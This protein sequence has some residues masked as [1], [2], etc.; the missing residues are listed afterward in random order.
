MQWLRHIAAWLLRFGNR[1]AHLELAV[2]LTYMPGI[3]CHTTNEKIGYRPLLG[4]IQIFHQSRMS[5]KGSANRPAE[6][7]M[8]EPELAIPVYGGGSV[9]RTQNTLPNNQ[10]NKESSIHAWVADD[11]L[12]DYFIKLVTAVLHCHNETCLH[13]PHPDIFNNNT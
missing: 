13:N 1:N 11:G 3:A 5:T 4:I 8:V 12:L 10:S 9:P 7:E 6:V 2:S